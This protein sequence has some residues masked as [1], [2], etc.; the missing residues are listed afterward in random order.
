MSAEHQERRRS[1]LDPQGAARL[2]RWL[3][4]YRP[5]SGVPDEL[6]D[7]TGR[8]RPYWL[9][10]LGDLAE[11]PEGEITARF[12][13][14]MRHI[15]DSGVSHRVWGE[16]AERSWP[17]GQAPLIIGP[18]EWSAL[19]AGVAQRARLMEAL[20]ADVYGEAR[21][22][23]EGAVPAAVITG[24]PDFIRAVRGAPAPGGR[25]LQLYAVDLG[26][27]PDG[28]WWVLSDRAQAPSGAGY[29]LEN[30]LVLSR[31]YPNLYNAMNVRRLA[32]FFDDLRQGLAA[33]A[34]R[35]DPR[36][37]LL[38]PGP[39]SE[40]YFEQAH[41]ARYLG[42]LLVEGDDLVARDGKVWVRTIAG[43]KRADV[44]WR[45][46]DADFV[47]PLELNRR[48]RLGVPG[49]LEAVRAGGVAVLN[50]P[51][52]GVV[53]SRALLPFLPSLCRRLLGEELALPS[54]A[55]WWC[56]QAF[57][58]ARVERDPD[59]AIAGAFD[60]APA[61]V[62]S[63]LSGPE[64][65]QLMAAMADRPADF[66]GQEVAQLSTTPVLR[67]DRLEPAPF[68]LRVFAAA[69]PDGFTV[70]PGGFC[71]TSDRA[72]AR[73]ISMGE[74][75]RTADVWVI[76]EEP[77]ER[78][79]LMPNQDEV[80]VRRVLGH[81]PGRAADNLFWLGRYLE[82]AE[83]T[84]RL[85]RSLCASL[86]DADAAVHG[87]GETLA[88][89]QSLLFAWGALP[90][91]TL[92]PDE[93]GARTSRPPGADEDMRPGRPRSEFY[94]ALGAARCALHEET[95]SG[96]AINLVRQAVRTAS[97][98]RERLSGDFWSLLVSLERGLVAPEAISEADAL[99]QV[100]QA[101]Q[102]LA[103][104]AGLAQE[105]M[106]RTA[107]W[108]FLDMGRRIERGTNICGFARALAGDT[109]TL[110]D[111]DLLLDLADSQITYRARYLAGLA[112]R[113][114][115]DM[116]MLDPFNTR[117]L[118]FQVETV[119]DHLAALPKLVEDGKL[120]PS[121]RIVTLLATE[122]ATADAGSIGPERALAFQDALTKLSNAIAERYFLQGANAI[123]TVKLSGLA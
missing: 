94:S 98:M 13:L 20:L 71:R 46:V 18:E 29:E 117:S 44:I 52:S 113:P 9:E 59:L 30:R 70:M 50:M 112:L 115:R 7:R 14:A 73:A 53:E 72:D 123:P 85:A 49:L 108:R 38:T 76:G 109:A 21:M 10:F 15:R 48:S 25:W 75:T 60:L 58:Q 122:I 91:P 6:F 17:L 79:T 65:I 12:N 69:T 62:M 64:R 31:A 101:L 86:M 93:N 68:V 110:D 45:R 120:E 22:V 57:E 11:Y 100:E 74:G 24:S 43:L 61:R 33:C 26:R 99:A 27:G 81:L 63:E 54:V 34:E 66:V 90:R 51:G 102:R 67:D 56:G 97:S 78:I 121:V 88:Q 5:L 96:S 82:R 47:D 42:F 118:A 107:G 8:P 37:C 103:A 41:L 36:I 92:A 23:R 4:G 55:T 39:Y 77:V 3:R 83:A 95:A 2:S 19:A 80:E 32:P 87:A 104:L 35:Q 28:R 1:D 106:N 40:T 16:D 111:L 89:L 114:V 105:N 116:V 119:K 84:L